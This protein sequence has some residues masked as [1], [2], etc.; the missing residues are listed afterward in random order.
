MAQASCGPSI[1]GQCQS[2]SLSWGFFSRGFVFFGVAIGE[3]PDRRS[4][5]II[6]NLLHRGCSGPPVTQP[7][8][9][10]PCYLLLP[11]LPNIFILFDLTLCFRQDHDLHLGR[12]FFLKRVFRLFS[13]TAS[14][15]PPTYPPSWTGLDWY[16]PSVIFPFPLPNHQFTNSSMLLLVF[17]L[18]PFASLCLFTALESVKTLVWR[19][20]LCQLR[21]PDP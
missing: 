1:M 16:L 20:G 18:F 6:L 21:T 9:F 7:S 3:Y 19:I 4:A 10:F 13:P 8:S 2:V 17:S 12:V 11:P 15:T 5:S 14:T